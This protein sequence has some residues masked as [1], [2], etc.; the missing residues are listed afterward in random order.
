MQTVTMEIVI[1][2]ALLSM[3][4]RKEQIQKE[5]EK[6]LVI[7]LFREGKISSG[8]AGS[9]LG[10]GRRDFLALLDREGIAYLDY[11]DEELEAEF[12]A[13]RELGMSEAKT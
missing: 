1:P 5:I 9:L 2:K 10:I 6:W 3:G 12:E 4:L 8:K 11:S 13:V 7:S